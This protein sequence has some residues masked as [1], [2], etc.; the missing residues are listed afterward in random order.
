M[1]FA[2]LTTYAIAKHQILD[3]SIVLRRTAIYAILVTLITATYFVVVLVAEKWLQGLVGYRS[4]LV[5]GTIG[6]L[7]A[8][9][10]LPLKNWVQTFV[11]R[12]FFHSTQAV[13]AEENERLRQEIVRTEKLKAVTTLAAGL[14]H[15]IKN[16]LASLKTFT[17]YLPER[18]DDPAFREKFARITGEEV[19]K[20]NDLVRR[21]LEFAK[22]APPQKQ[23]VKLS[24]LLDET[25]EFLDALQEGRAPR[26]SPA[27]VLPLA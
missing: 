2:L 13:L 11:D 4:L 27:D 6:F 26:P 12:Y 17:Q 24:R 10:F 23:P 7:I 8:V 14:A 20:I 15:E 9:G 3:F 1:A 22:P 5:S 19:E 18:Y 25:V 21:L 16:P